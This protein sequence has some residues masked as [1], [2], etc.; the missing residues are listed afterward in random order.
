MQLHKG[1]T[2]N[3]GLSEKTSNFL[4]ANCRTKMQ[5]SKLKSPC[6]R[7]KHDVAGCKTCLLLSNTLSRVQIVVNFCRVFVVQRASVFYLFK[8]KIKI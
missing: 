2:L 4:L 8:S 6:L 1:H 7:F 3:F 5:N